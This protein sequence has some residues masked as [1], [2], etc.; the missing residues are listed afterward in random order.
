VFAVL[1]ER[2]SAESR[3]LLAR[4]AEADRARLV[5]ALATV[6]EVLDTAPASAGYTVRPLRAGDLGWVVSRHGALYDQEYGW[7]ADFEALVARIVADYGEKHRP[8]RD[9]AWIAEVD[10]VPVGCVLCVQKNRST[11]QLRLLLVEPSARGMGIGRRLVD[12]C[13]RFARSAGYQRMTLWTNDVLIAA[14]SIYEAAGFRLVEEEKHHSF[15]HDLV[16]QNWDLDL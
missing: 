9:N 14:R 11:A 1:D 4:L 6:G 13:V 16:G 15:G 8:G 10:G 3:E 2:S 5:A 12:E 7:D